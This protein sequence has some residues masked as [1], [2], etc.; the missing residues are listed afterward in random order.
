M[1]Q[2]IFIKFDIGDKYL[3]RVVSV[4]FYL[5][6]RRFGAVIAKCLGGRFLGHS[7]DHSNDF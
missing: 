3:C 1:E 7:V 2:A 4:K 5:N 6:R